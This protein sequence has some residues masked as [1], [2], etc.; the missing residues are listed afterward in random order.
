[1]D[2]ALEYTKEAFRSRSDLSYRVRAAI[3]CAGFRRIGIGVHISGGTLVAE[4]TDRLPHLGQWPPGLRVFVRRVK[5]LRDTTPKP[6][7]G[8]AAQLELDGVAEAVRKAVTG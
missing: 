3:G 8:V 4:L 1:M 6:L 5:P 7:P 2:H